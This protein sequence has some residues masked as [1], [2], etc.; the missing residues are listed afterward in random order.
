MK[1]W[2]KNIALEVE[3]RCY[4]CGGNGKHEESSQGY[5]TSGKICSI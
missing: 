1:E 3:I 5:V 4:K 2:I